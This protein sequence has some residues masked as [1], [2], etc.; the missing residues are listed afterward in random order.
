MDVTLV[1]TH[2][3]N[4]GCAYC[5]AGAKFQKRMSP[6]TASRAIALAFT[7]GAP[8]VQ[9]SFFGGEPLLAWDEL[10]RSA[11][12]ARALAEARGV[13]LVMS[14]TTNGTLLDADRAATLD[15]LGVYVALSIDGVRE[16]HDAGR[17]RA[18]GGSS[19]DQVARGLEVLLRRG[20]PFETISVVTPQNAHLVGASVEWL[21]AQ[22]VPRV[23]LN[24]CYEAAFDDAAL[25]AWERG[26]E[27][28]AE[29][30]AGHFRSGRVVSLTTFDNK[31]LAAVKGGLSAGDRCSLGTRSVA[32]APGGNLYACERLVGEDD[33]ASLVIGHV[34][35]WAGPAGEA[36]ARGPVNPACE[37]CGERWRCS[38]HCA[39]ANRAE[40][41]RT[42]V[43]GGTQ[44]WHERTTARIADGLAETLWAEQ[45]P[46]FLA[47]FY[48]RSLPAGTTANGAH[49][50]H[51]SAH[52]STPM[53][54][55]H[56]PRRSV[57]R[58]DR[59]AP[60]TA[61]KRLVVVR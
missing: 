12:E 22:G 61:R 60:V 14:V 23:G 25:A 21:F 57:G 50:A 13:A 52:A 40:T 26:L 29:V 46:A 59:R 30:V 7:D 56:E 9:I 11:E 39:C 4:L 28:A 1:L 51:A 42:D 54:T 55:P 34:D 45:N 24:P 19:F 8:R 2:D 27:H 43:A 6:E 44:C 18:G 3:C 53:R 17:P 10:V 32:V 37:P 36:C 41:G 33:D 5:Y 15:A 16:A 47:W 48:G 35:D 20:T 49:E 31:I 38:S 58:I